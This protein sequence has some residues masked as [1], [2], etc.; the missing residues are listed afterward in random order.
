VA[1]RGRAGWRGADLEQHGQS[2]RRPGAEAEV[3]QAFNQALSM[4][5]TIGNRQAEALTLNNT[6]R[7]YRDL[8]QQQ[9]AMDYYNQA[10]PIWRETGNR[11]GRGWLSTISAGPMP[12]WSAAKGTGIQRAGVADLARDW[13]PA[14]RSDDAEQHGPGL[15][16]PGRNSKA[17][18]YDSEALHI[19]HEVE[20]R[21]GEALAMMTIGWHTRRGKSQKRRWRANWRLC[22]WRRPR[23]I[24]RF[25][26]ELKPR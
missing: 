17:L 13:D 1:R 20:D 18:E 11:I 12:T 4:S 14:R 19:W 25:K 9:T 5:R 7:L 26:A 22:L 2:V 16:Q 23:A 8:G 3:L 10:L 6:G 15:F 24:R 21:R